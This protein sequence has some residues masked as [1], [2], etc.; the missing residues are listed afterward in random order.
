MSITTFKEESYVVGDGVP[1]ANTFLPKGK[2]Y[3]DRQTGTVYS[4]SGE[5]WSQ[6]GG[7]G[8]AAPTDIPGCVLWL[9]A[10]TLTG[11][12]PT[13]PVPVW[14]D[15]VGDYQAIGGLAYEGPDV[16]VDPDLAPLFSIDAGNFPGL[17]FDGAASTMTVINPAVTGS[18]EGQS[19]VT[20]AIV[21]KQVPDTYSALGTWVYDTEPYEGEGGTSGNIPIVGMG[22]SSSYDHSE[23]SF[24]AS[25]ENPPLDSSMS[26]G[27][28]DYGESSMYI[29]PLPAYLPYEGR[30]ALIGTADLNGHQAAVEG[31]TD[32][33]NVASWN[34]QI[35]PTFDDY[36]PS[37][38][39]VFPAMTRYCHGLELVT[40]GY[41]DLGALGDYFQGTL[42][43]F[44]VFNRALNVD[45]RQ[46]LN[47]YLAAK[48]QLV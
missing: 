3:V 14:T 38:A 32:I 4:F 41:T 2:L 28:L 48:W 24:G 17:V 20:Y 40:R 43:E 23:V 19:G 36:L 6:V 39:Q 35:Y 21:L 25:I 30:F 18:L 8:L 42:H 11:F 22:L 9:D 44:I 37:G 34:A 29:K 7:G 33:L 16:P 45:E 13:D 15:R 12:D 47:A 46:K 26:Y 27:A 1:T 10:T 5:T 31:S